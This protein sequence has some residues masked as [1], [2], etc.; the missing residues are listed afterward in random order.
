MPP[1]GLTVHSQKFEEDETTLYSL[2]TEYLEAATILNSTA[3][4][5]FN[6]SIVTFYL[7]GHAAEL[8][9]KSFLY[10]KGMSIKE[11][12]DKNKF[13]HD[14]AKLSTCARGKGLKPSVALKHISDLSVIYKDKQTEYRKYR[15]TGLVEFPPLDLL[16][17]EVSTLQNHVFNH[18]ARF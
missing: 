4:T 14:L 6:Y 12:R 3:P 11:L 17:E 8:L 18:I 5:R 9:L 16:F 10:K 13:G 15:K 2:S 7:V 1:F